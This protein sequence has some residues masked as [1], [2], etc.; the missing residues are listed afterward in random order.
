[1]SKIKTSNVTPRTNGGSLTIGEPRSTTY[2]HKD[3]D[4]VI[5]GYATKDYVDEVASAAP[6]G[7]PVFHLNDNKLVRSYTIPEGK[8]AGTFGELEMSDNV[9]VH[10]PDGSTWTIVGNKEVGSDGTIALSDLVD[11][12]IPM[13][14]QP[15]AMLWYDEFSGKWK[16]KTISSLPPGEAGQDGEDGKSAYEIYAETTSDSPVKTVQEWL[17]SLQGADGEDGKDS[18]EV[19][20]EKN[21]GS[22]EEDYWE[23][24]RGP[25]GP[26]G[27][28]SFDLWLADNPGGTEEEYWA[29][30]EG[31]QGQPGPGFDYKGNVATESD[32]PNDSGNPNSDGDAYF[33]EDVG[34]L[35]AWG[36]DDQWH[37][38]GQI[39][40]EQGE[41]GDKGETG[42]SAYEIWLK[43]NPG[44]TE[45]EFLDSLKGETGDAG[46]D[47]EDG[48]GQMVGVGSTVTLD[49][50]ESATVT[51]NPNLST[52]EKI[53][54]DFGIPKG[55]D[56]IDGLP[57]DEGLPG[58]DGASAYESW[59]AAGN[60]GSEQDFLDSIVGDKGDDG[61]DGL[62]AYEV[63]IENGFSGTEEEWLNSLVGEKGPQG[64]GIHVKGHVSDESQLP[65]TAEVGDAYGDD[66]GD[67]W[68]YSDSGTW[69]NFGRV[70]GPAGEDGKD[71][72]S[73]YASA[74]DAGFQGS[75]EEWI[76]SLKGDE[77]EPGESI[78]GDPGDDGKSAYDIAV[79]QG[80][81]G[82]EDQWLESLK[83]EDGLLDDE[84]LAQIQDDL[85]QI[86]STLTPS[87][88]DTVLTGH[89]TNNGD[90]TFTHTTSW[91]KVKHPD[92]YFDNSHTDDGDNV[93]VGIEALSMNDVGGAR[94]NV[95]VGYFSLW[96]NWNGT[97]ST[98]IGYEAAKGNIAGSQNVAIG[99]WASWKNQ[100]GK[101]NTVIGS[102]AALESQG[103]NGNVIIGKGAGYNTSGNNNIVIGC[104]ASTSS[105]TAEA[106]IVIGTPAQ[107]SFSVP[108]VGLEITKDEILHNGQ[109][110]G[111]VGDDSDHP[112][113]NRYE[114]WKFR[115]QQF[116]GWPI[117]DPY[118]QIE[119]VHAAE[120]KSVAG[121][122]LVDAVVKVG[123]AQDPAVTTPI[124]MMYTAPT[125][126]TYGVSADLSG[127]P[128]A[129]NYA[130]SAYSPEKD[131]WVVMKGEQPEGFPIGDTAAYL[132]SNSD[133]FSFLPATEGDN[134]SDV[135]WTSVIWTGINGGTFQALGY[136]RS[137]GPDKARNWSSYDG[138]GWYPNTRTSLQSYCP[139]ARLNPEECDMYYLVTFKTSPS[140]TEEGS[141]NNYVYRSET[142]KLGEG[143]AT[144]LDYLDGPTPKVID[145]AYGNGVTVAVFEDVEPGKPICAASMTEGFE[146][147]LG[148]FFGWD[149]SRW[150]IAPENPDLGQNFTGGE[151]RPFEGKV[152]GITF[153]GGRFVITIDT[154]FVLN[155]ED[156]VRWGIDFIS[157]DHK[158][159]G[160]AYHLT[161]DANSSG[162]PNPPTHK[163]HFI[164]ASYQNYVDGSWVY[165]TAY[166]YKVDKF[167]GLSTYDEQGSKLAHY[168]DIEQL[169]A[170]IAE[171]K[172]V[173]A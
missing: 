70:Q 11:T 113:W 115:F 80:F 122:T 79:E 163:C 41:E 154:G 123:N 121:N 109:P 98:A 114:E 135:V 10:I 145:C 43:S 9:D 71:G 157:K 7:N 60:S 101:F 29:S 54:L 86:N 74:L 99:S 47:G 120:G 105:P 149:K 23:S 97:H 4:V 95:A 55:L 132:D 160:A 156:G 159:T 48:L 68:V 158:I 141:W 66:N 92:P 168:S 42:D 50:G 143:V 134:I 139:M 8:N 19:W 44:K 104:V 27:L 118:A 38:L 64:D 155:S 34:E 110:I 63:A 162:N 88:D 117:E 14:P 53:I 142:G 170:E 21:P 82:T 69:I 133:T 49:A 30:L 24:M 151:N 51:Q 106:E 59:L 94:A 65:P 127:T 107:K 26:D 67:L 140:S 77:G 15:D 40:G 108:G 112:V 83:G 126:D 111:G 17:D 36:A 93:A 100:E 46:E 89:V 138:R 165:G 45:Q 73:A 12:D 1:M 164:D 146:G 173:K 22:S 61:E 28:S 125:G 144:S 91:E 84:T 90:G 137:D 169:K 33:V 161:D 20:L 57:G 172:N 130:C 167:Y 3:S 58:A 62:S 87:S 76:A 152:Q 35:F 75:E 166:Q 103:G 56:G 136:K 5:P 81:Q 72:K 102:E 31:P 39:Q 148:Y 124:K 32:L 16:P 119:W 131:I 85:T 2:F 116:G 153:T 13:I 128:L 52:Q 6:H 78:K 96:N 150:F 18:L 129:G 37:S 147:Q 25:I 171:L